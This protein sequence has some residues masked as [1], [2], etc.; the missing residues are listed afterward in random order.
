MNIKLNIALLAVALCACPLVRAGTHYVNK[1]NA[2]PSSPF[3]GWSSAAM[4]IQD[5]I[6]L[7]GRQRIRHGTV[8]IGTYELRVKSGTIFRGR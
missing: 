2:M 4:N 7:D 6:D 5:A 1:A 8:Y 3:A